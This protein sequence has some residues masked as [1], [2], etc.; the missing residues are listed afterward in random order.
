MNVNK[1]Y[2]HLLVLISTDITTTL[3]NNISER[4]RC[5]A[6]LRNKASRPVTSDDHGEDSFEDDLNTI[7]SDIDG[8]DMLGIE[9]EMKGENYDDGDEFCREWMNEAREE[10]SRRTWN[11]SSSSS[12]SSSSI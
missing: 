11:S 4:V 7:G 2:A 10:D 5:L 3:T 1:Y 9:E 6:Y 12:S 8:Q